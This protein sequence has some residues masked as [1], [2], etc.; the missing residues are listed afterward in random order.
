MKRKQ[1]L[2]ERKVKQL[3]KLRLILDTDKD[4][5]LLEFYLDSAGDIICSLRNSDIVEPEYLNIQIRMAVELY[6]KRG[7]EGQVSHSELGID[8]IYSRA[9]ISYDL[10]DRI[11]PVARTPFSEKRVIECDY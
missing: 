10:L 3:S 2:E 9:D 5:E 7:A 4:D 11:V 6:A 1:L 8:R